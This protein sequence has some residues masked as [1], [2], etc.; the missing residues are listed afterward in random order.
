M[1]LEVKT[2]RSK[3]TE[4]GNFNAETVWL[5]G[6]KLLVEPWKRGSDTPVAFLAQA[7]QAKRQDC[8]FHCIQRAALN[9]AEPETANTRL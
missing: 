9:P 2:L 6:W 5:W 4:L 1:G 8:R 3:G 7:V